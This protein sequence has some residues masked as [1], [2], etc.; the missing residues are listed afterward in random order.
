MDPLRVAV[1]DRSAA[2]VFTRDLLFIK[3]PSD[4]YWNYLLERMKKR[5]AAWLP[6]N[7]INEKTEK[8]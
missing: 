5:K 7:N 4:D 6:S 8:T 3:E 1:T 2:M